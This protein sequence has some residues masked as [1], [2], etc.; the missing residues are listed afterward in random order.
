MNNSNPFVPQGSLLDQQNKRRSRMKLGVFCVLAFG[1]AG[2]T[3]MLIQGC[4][5]EAE[6]TDNTSTMDTNTPAVDTNAPAI[7]TNTPVVAPVVTNPPVMVSPPVETSGTEYTVLKGDSFAKIAKEHGVSVKAIEAANPGIE[8]TKL[9][10]GQKLSVPAASSAPVAGTTTSTDTGGEIYVVK[11]GDTLSSIA[12][13]YGTTVK[14]IEAENNLSTTKIVVGR[15]L[16]IPAKTEAAAPAP[17][18]AEI[19]PPVT[20]AATPSPAH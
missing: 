4:K 8:P 19:A 1:I 9:K 16:K 15:K 18:P 10:V 11:S 5:R 6:T 12:K 3:A 7:D 14:A 2:L 13:H 20:P 17:A